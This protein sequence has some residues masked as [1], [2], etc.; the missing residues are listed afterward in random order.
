MC[1]F[2]VCIHSF[3][4]NP[5]KVRVCILKETAYHSIFLLKRELSSYIEN[6]LESSERRHLETMEVIAMIH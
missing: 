3:N 2:L 4:S 6:Q 5:R 1:R